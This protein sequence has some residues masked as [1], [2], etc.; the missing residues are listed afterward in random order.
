MHLVPISS[1]SCLVAFSKSSECFYRTVQVPMQAS[2]YSN[3]AGLV[4]E[5]HIPQPSQLSI[6]VPP[7]ASDF[8]SWKSCQSSVLDGGISRLMWCD[9]R[10]W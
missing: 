2:K 5:A 7:P 4:R 1:F 8:S 9:G 6:E 10:Q 3:I